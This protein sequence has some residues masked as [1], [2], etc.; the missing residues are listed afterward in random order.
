MKKLILFLVLP[1]VLELVSCNNVNNHTEFKADSILVVSSITY[2][3]K[4]I[5]SNREIESILSILNNSDWEKHN[6]KTV[7]DFDFS[8]DGTDKKIYYTFNDGLFNDREN[9]RHLVVSNE[10][11]E[12][13]NSI[14]ESVFDESTFAQLK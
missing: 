4:A 8:F 14:L 5:E 2:S 11:R 1:L 3:E 7:Y 12:L 10:Q 9:N 13:I 6:T